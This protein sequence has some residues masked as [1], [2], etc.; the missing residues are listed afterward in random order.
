MTLRLRQ[1]LCK[2]SKRRLR[3]RRVRLRTLD[4]LKA[5]LVEAVDIGVLF[6]Q[7][8]QALVQRVGDLEVVVTAAST[9]V[10]V[11]RRLHLVDG[12]DHLLGLVDH[13]LLLA[14]H[15]AHLALERLGQSIKELGLSAYHY[16]TDAV[17]THLCLARL[18]VMV[19]D[20]NL[21]KQAMQLAN[22]R[23]DLLGQVAG[24]HG[25]ERR[26]SRDRV[27]LVGALREKKVM[28][29]PGMGAGSVEECRYRGVCLALSVDGDC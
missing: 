10:V 13:F 29:S 12:G 14:R 23:V 4:L 28:Q 22:A 2:V 20:A 9:V 21:V 18:A 16:P 27:E 3:R 1:V 11:E 15:Q 19:R 7:L 24:V 17:K 8:L 26:R 25:V 6:L 5:L